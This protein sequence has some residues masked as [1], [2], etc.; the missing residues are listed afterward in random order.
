M[1]EGR[2]FMEELLQRKKQDVPPQ[3]PEPKKE[4]TLP[5]VTQPKVKV[6]YTPEVQKLREKALLSNDQ[7][8]GVEFA[9]TYKNE[10]VHSG[11]VVKLGGV[12]K[13]PKKYP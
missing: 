5:E 7:I 8:L 3:I 9:S 10:Y 13:K 11:V 4:T 12:L 2:E 1:I 6:D